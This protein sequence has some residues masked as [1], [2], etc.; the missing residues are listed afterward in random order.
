MFELV[1]EGELELAAS[2]DP[3]SRT[4]E[5]RLVKLSARG[6]SYLTKPNQGTTIH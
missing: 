5:E 4:G 6:F 2:A 3:A 1:P